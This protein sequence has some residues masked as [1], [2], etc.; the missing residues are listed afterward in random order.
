[1]YRIELTGKCF[2]YDTEQTI[3][4]WYS[5]KCE[6]SSLNEFVTSCW[7]KQYRKENCVR[8]TVDEWFADFHIESVP[9]E[10][11]LQKI[12]EYISNLENV[13]IDISSRYTN[14]ICLIKE[15]WNEAIYAAENE[16]D[17]VCFL[18]YTTA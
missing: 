8:Q 12:H 18:W 15:A 17:Y 3:I 11:F 6:Y 4:L 7:K 14:A 1:M 16:Y 10:T 2:K 9:V 5:S 13:E